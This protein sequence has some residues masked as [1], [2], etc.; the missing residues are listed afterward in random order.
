MYCFN[1]EKIFNEIP[2]IEYTF[3]N[4]YLEFYKRHLLVDEFKEELDNFYSNTNISVNLII[5]KCL[6]INF[7]N[8]IEREN[9]QSLE[10]NYFNWR[11]NKNEDNVELFSDNFYYKILDCIINKIIECFDKCESEDNCCS[12][13]LEKNNVNFK[14]NKCNLFYDRDCL[15]KYILNNFRY[16]DKENDKIYNSINYEI[17]CPQCRKYFLLDFK[18]NKDSFST[19]FKINASNNSKTSIRKL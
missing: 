14:C 6:T 4:E 16:Y 5:F 19:D 15:I 12:I 11:N 3:S 10:R 9:K 13:C 2:N 18:I 17:S 8:F 1:Y 7:D